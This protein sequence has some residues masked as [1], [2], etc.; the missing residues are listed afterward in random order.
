[1]NTCLQ[2]YPRISSVS[3]NP[4]KPSGLKRANPRKKPNLEAKKMSQY[5]TLPERLLRSGRR[6]LCPVW[7]CSVVA[8]PLARTQISRRMEARQMEVIS[9]PS[10]VDNASISLS[11]TC[12][13][14]NRSLRYTPRYLHEFDLSEE[15]PKP[16]HFYFCRSFSTMNHLS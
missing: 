6:N 15:A 2:S 11:V 7:L 5:K 13:G 1:M 4:Q 16:S 10:F 3:L 9:M 12:S 8:L 14:V